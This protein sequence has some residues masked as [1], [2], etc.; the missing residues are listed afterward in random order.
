MW[1]KFDIPIETIS[2]DVKSKYDNLR[3]RNTLKHLEL[4]FYPNSRNHRQF[5]EECEEIL[6]N[7]SLEEKMESTQMSSFNICWK[8]QERSKLIFTQIVQIRC[9][10]YYR[11]CQVKSLEEEKPE[12]KQM[13]A[14]QFHWK[15]SS[16]PVQIEK[17][18]SAKGQKISETNLFH[19]ILKFKWKYLVILS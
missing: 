2:K 11:C 15:K 12:L 10:F 13:T 9:V 7:L 19:I 5:F 8:K 4:D 6:F 14:E 1:R 17:S 16:P 18:Y 3:M